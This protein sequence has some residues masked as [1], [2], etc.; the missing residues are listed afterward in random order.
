MSAKDINLDRA[1]ADVS[2]LMDSVANKPKE[3]YS[4]ARRGLEVFDSLVRECEA[5]GLKYISVQE[6]K[7]AVENVRAAHIH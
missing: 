1:A 3:S 7:E 5:A 2:A 6:L 4:N